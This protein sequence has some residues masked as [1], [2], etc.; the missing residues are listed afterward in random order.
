MSSPFRRSLPARPDLAQQKTQARELLQAFGRDESEAVARVRAALP[1]KSRISL[2]DAQYVIAREYGFESWSRLRQHIETLRADQR[3]PIERAHDAFERRDAAALRRLL[4]EHADFRQMINAPVMAFNSPPIVACANDAGMIEVLLEFGANPNAKSEWWA[5][6]FHPLYSATGVA[7]ER[8]IAA[9]A[10]LDACAAAHLDRT[11]VLRRLIE[12]DP[13]CVH[14]RGGDGQTPLH[15]AR[16]I[17]TVNILLAAGADIDARDVDHRSSP[18][19]WMLDCARDRG[20]FALAL[21]LVERG[22]AADIFLCAALG[23]TPR[24]RDLL[25]ADPSLLELRTGQG[26]YGEMPPSSFHIYEWTIGANRSPLDVAA[27]FGHDETVAAML[28]LASA[29]Q[30]F[31][32]AAMHRDE[33]TARAMLATQPT[34]LASLAPT[35][36][37]A[38]S[39]AAWSGD[40]ESVRLMLALGFDP[41]VSGHDFGTAL[42]CAAW[43]GSVSSVA[44]ILEHRDAAALLR[45]KDAQYGATPLGWCCHGSLNGHRA[46][47]HAG[48]ARLLIAAGAQIGADTTDASDAVLEI[49]SVHR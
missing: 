35:Q 29:A 14:E 23:L 44:A 39:D 49:L 7:A 1:N 8:L 13:Q 3:T 9:G 12:A 46:R 45:V 27:Q 22:A 15:F 4:T 38:L 41:R 16:S 34:L 32:F 48:V 40:A 21:Y 26:A 28:P 42:H 33:S 5:G 25:G 47:D 2:A 10:T 18:A 24:V 17:E 36:Q 19:E 6:G 20:R 11:D 31:V 30:R 37:R 43:Q